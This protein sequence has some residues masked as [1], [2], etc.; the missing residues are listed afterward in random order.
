MDTC[1]TVPDDIRELIE[2][3]DEAL[4]GKRFETVLR[5]AAE[6]PEDEE[7]L[8]VEVLFTMRMLALGWNEYCRESTD[9]AQH[10]G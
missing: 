10:R 3:G 1:E 9:Q 4:P 8:S 5:G 6:A 7:E 2:P